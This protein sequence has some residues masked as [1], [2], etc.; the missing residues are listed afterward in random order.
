MNKR[1]LFYGDI[2]VDIVIETNDFPRLGEDAVVRYAS[3]LPGGSS[4]NSA[5][6]AGRLGACSYYMGLVGN[7]I[8]QSMLV[9]D[10]E[11]NNVRTN[12]I[13]KVEGKNSIIIAMVDGHGERTF[14]SYRGVNGSV[15]YGMI[16]RGLTQDFDCVHLS[17]YSMQD[18]FSRE[19]S[20]ALVTDAK[21]SGVLL[22]L[23]PSHAFAKSHYGNDRGFLSN[24]DIVMPN[25]NE[26]ELMTREKDPQKAAKALREMGIKMVVVKMSGDGCWLSYQDRELQIPAFVVSKFRNTIGAGDAFCSGFLVG[27]LHGIAPEYAVR[28]GNAAANLILKGEGGHSHMPNL[29][30]VIRMI[31]DLEG[32]DLSGLIANNATSKPIKDKQQ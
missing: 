4:A 29:E 14:F 27:L 31:Y 2:G 21:E 11:E 16:N 13:R 26:A 5:V 24:F 9:R 30:E 18:K 19:T 7:D 32:I 20:L 28:T 25:Q 10:L 1:I 12:Y 22:S 17:G 6:V 15:N 3:T 23:D 8:Y